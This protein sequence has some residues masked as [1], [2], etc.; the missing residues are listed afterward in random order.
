M[1]QCRVDLPKQ[2]GLYVNPL[3]L[4]QASGPMNIHPR[5]C[6]IISN[7]RKK[8]NMKMKRRPQG[9]YLVHA[10]CFKNLLGR[11]IRVRD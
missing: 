11:K 7:K 6:K 1:L 5:P 2:P 3:L 8:F 9:H 4:G 10:L